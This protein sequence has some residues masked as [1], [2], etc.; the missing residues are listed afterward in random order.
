MAKNVVLNDPLPTLGN[1]S[2]WSIT[3]DPSGRCT[4]VANTLNCLFG[5][6]ANGQT[7][8]VTVATTAAGGADPT[9]CPGNQKLNNTATV[10]STG[11]QPKSDTGDYLCTP[12][13]FTVTKTPKNEI[14]KIGDNVNFTITVASTGPGVAKN[15]VLNDPLPTLGNMNSWS[16][17]SGPTGGSCSIVANTLSCVFGDLANGQTRVVTV[18]TTTTGGADLTACP[19]NQKL[20]N[21]ATVTATGLPPKSDTGDYLCTPPPTMCRGVGLCRIDIATGTGAPTTFCNAALGQACNLPLAIAEVAKTNT[22]SSATTRTI[23]VHGVCRGDPVLIKGLFNLVIQGE[24]PSDTTHNGCSNDKGPLPGDLKSEVSRKDPPFNAP[25]GSNGE[26]IKLV[27]SNRVTIKYLNIRDGRFPLTAPDQKAQLADDGVDIKTSTA[28]RAFCNCIE[29]NEEGLDV[30]G[31]TCNQ[32]D[33]NLVRKNEDGIRASAGAKWIRYSN[34]TSENNDLAQTDTA[35]DLA[36]RHN[37]LMLT[38]SATSN[39][40]VGNVAKNDAAIR[41]DDGLKF[42]GANGNCASDNDITKFGKTSNPSP[43]SDDTWGCEIFNSS[44]N[45]VFRNRFSGNITLN[46]APADFCKLVSGTGNCGDS[47]PGTAACNVTTC[48]PLFPSDSTGSTPCTVEP[49]R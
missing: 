40:F 41:S 14:Y 8:T 48:P 9:A 32:V 18:A 2:S 29:N 21:T 39:N 7:R 30:D 38:E 13:S 43:S 45:K 1:L 42:Y 34:N 20:N 22:T 25:T 16:I 27:S 11:L 5:D 46:G 6:L 17:A 44:N 4:L 12:G 36:G 47:I 33:Q 15:V 3:S 24:A 35:S 37:G 23:S 49:L 19:G 31:G 10:T 28:S 26:V